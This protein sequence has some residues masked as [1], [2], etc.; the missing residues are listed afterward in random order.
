VLHPESPLLSSG[1]NFRQLT[2]M[3]GDGHWACESKQG[4]RFDQVIIIVGKGGVGPLMCYGRV[5]GSDVEGILTG[6]LGWRDMEE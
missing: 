4:P 3:H 6:E 5:I 2:R 1:R